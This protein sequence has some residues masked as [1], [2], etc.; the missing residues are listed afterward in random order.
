MNEKKTLQLLKYLSIYFASI[1]EADS[2]DES[3]EDMT[4]SEVSIYLPCKH[5][6]S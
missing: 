4:A 1:V 2:I 5:S 6:R 3:V